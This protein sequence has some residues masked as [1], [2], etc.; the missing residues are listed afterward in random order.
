[1]SQLKKP[2][3]KRIGDDVIKPITEDERK[4]LFPNGPVSLKMLRAIK[5][6]KLKSK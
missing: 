3:S 1:M 4:A 2:P 6:Q 5:S